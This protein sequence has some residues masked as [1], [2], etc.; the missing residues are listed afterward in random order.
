MVGMVDTWAL[1]MVAVGMVDT[2][3]DRKGIAFCT[4]GI[5]FPWS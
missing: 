4:V 3:R 2:G 1:W 5:T